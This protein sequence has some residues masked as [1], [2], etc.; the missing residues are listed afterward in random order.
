MQVALSF[1]TSKTV[2][3]ILPKNYY[4]RGLRG[5]FL[6][7]LA[8]DTKTK[9][10]N[11]AIATV[12]GTK[13]FPCQCNDSGKAAAYGGFQKAF[14]LFERRMSSWTRIWL[15]TKL[16]SWLKLS[17]ITSTQS[18]CSSK[19]SRTTHPSV[20]INSDWH[21]M[22]RLAAVIALSREGFSLLRKRGIYLISNWSEATIYRVRA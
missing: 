18:I 15:Y 19:L 1:L 20:E 3:L 5:L 4:I 10:T 17:P 9:T 14:A 8:K 11:Q 22:Q 13:A 12:C 7:P 21:R 2:Y 16:C 6:G